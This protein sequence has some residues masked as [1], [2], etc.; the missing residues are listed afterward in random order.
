MKKIM[1]VDNDRIMLK[2]MSR[3]LEKEGHQ[4]V[5]AEDGLQALD[6]LM[7]YTPDVIIVDLIMPN[8]DGKTLCKIIRNMHKLK[9]AYLIMLSAIAAEEKINIAQLGVN[10]CIAKGPFNETAEHVLAVLDQPV[11]SSSQCLTEEVIGINGVYPRGITEELLSAK[12]HFEVVLETITE[13]I[14]EINSSGRI[15]Y[16]NST[17]LSLI[18]IPEE[19]LLGTYFYELF[20]DDDRNRV[21]DLM[22]NANGRPQNISEDN[23]LHLNKHQVSLN[24][25]PI[26]TGGFS[27]IIILN[28]LSEQKRT[29]AALRKTNKFLKNILDSSYSI[30]I[31]STDLDQN[32]LF[33]NKGAENIFGYKAEEIVGRQKIDILYHE[34]E[35]RRVEHEIRP[36]ILKDKK[37]GSFVIKEVTRDKRILWMYLNLAPRFDD[38]GNIIG[39]LGV[40]EDITERKLAEEALKESQ[41]LLSAII[42]S[43]ADGILVVDDKG[44]VIHANKRFAQLWKIPDKLIKRGNDKQLLQFVLDQLVDPELFLQKVKALY[45]SSEEDFD[46]ILFKDNCIFERYSSPLVQDEKIAGRVWSFRDITENRRMEEQ[47]RQAQKM[48]AIGTLAGGVAHD[49]NNLLMG[50]RGRTSLMMSD[51]DLSYPHNEHVK[52]IESY[53]NSAAELTN[54]LLAFA[55]GGK[56][57]VKPTDLNKLVKSQNRMFGRTKKEIA[58]RGKY[59]ENLW[60]AEIDKGQIEQVLLNLYVNAWQSMPGGGNL[61]IQ[62]ENVTLD[63]NHPKKLFEMTPGKYVKISV[64]DTGVGMDETTRKKMFDPFFTTKEMG[65]GTGLGLASAYGI[66]KNHGGFIDVYS[67]QGKGST[68]NIYLPASGK[69]VIEEPKLSKDVLKGAETVLLVDDENMIIDVGKPMLEKLGYNALIARSGKSTIE[70]YKDKKD[71]ID[72]VILDMIMPEMDGGDTYDRLRKINPEIKVLLSSGYSVY[73]QATEI[74]KRGCNGFIQKPFSMQDLSQKIREIMDKK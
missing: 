49:F 13:G 72:I 64:A 3:L 24:I 57:E 38:N 62:T 43:T 61:Y 53:V 67:E 28:D 71:Q 1:V 12:R 32:I 16:A 25:L 9:D 23:P 20:A 6:M 73:G 27:S 29:E 55:R 10:A 22:E 2:L 21:T 58:I 33:W 5:T 42:E 47:L 60:S 40:G 7:D 14:L 44:K 70:I 51:T 68:F 4:V 17:A 50:I 56:Y 8:I 26:K 48:E 52:G 31:I 46:T 54:Q 65:R 36:L 66:I 15:I 34:E 63:E 39:I 41:G 69:K 37:A 11:L 74:L 45:D 30:S 35:K 19:N 18:D 59:E